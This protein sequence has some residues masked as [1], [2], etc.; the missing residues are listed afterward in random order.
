MMP[1]NIVHIIFY[2]YELFVLCF[3]E[4][5]RFRIEF[6]IVYNKVFSS[7]AVVGL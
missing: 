2:L 3:Y 1:F 5:T 7:V 6:S 4:P